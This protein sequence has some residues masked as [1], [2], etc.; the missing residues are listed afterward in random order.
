[1]SRTATPY[2]SGD[3]VATPDGRGVVL[4]IQSED[5]SFPQE[6]HDHADVEASP[7][8]PAF[9]VALEEG[10]SATYRERAL[11]STTF[12]ETDLPEPESE[13]VTDVVDEGVDSGDRLPEGMDRSEALEYWSD[14]GGS[15]SACVSDREDELGEQTA[16]AQCTAIKDLL[17]GTERWRE[18]F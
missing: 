10:G 14:L 16:E 6:G 9:V 5:F 13:R 11:E 7:E 2:E 3:V 17:A 8:R 4:A 1:M 15:W 12:G 18:H